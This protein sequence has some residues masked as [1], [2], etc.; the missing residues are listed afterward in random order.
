MKKPNF[1]TDC[2][3]MNIVTLAITAVVKSITGIVLGVCK[4]WGVE[5]GGE[6]L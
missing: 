4:F 6:Y 1:D 5:G 3:T 2:T